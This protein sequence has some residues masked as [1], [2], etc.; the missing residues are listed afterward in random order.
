MKLI[1]S[2]IVPDDAGDPRPVGGYATCADIVAWPR[3]ILS[4]TDETLIARAA[5][6]IRGGILFSSQYSGI[7]GF[8]DR[9]SNENEGSELLDGL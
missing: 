9:I 6:T 2:H 1:A 4:Q 5:Q 3:V 7:D 8:F